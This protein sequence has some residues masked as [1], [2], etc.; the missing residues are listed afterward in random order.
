MYPC[1][2]DNNT[3]TPFDTHYLYHTA[4]AARIIKKINP[5]LHID[6]GSCL[7]FNS[8]I[9][10]F[11]PVLHCDFRPPEIRLPNLEIQHADITNLTFKNASVRSLSC[12]HVIEHIG[13]GRYG[14]LLDQ[15][16]DLK[17]VR[18]L[19]RVLAVGGHLLIC[20]PI[21]GSPR[22]EFNAHRVYS[23]RMVLDM[24]VDLKLKEYSLI[25][26][27]AY[28]KGI[29]VNASEDETNSQN[30]GC[31]CFHFIKRSIF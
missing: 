12:M 14:D 28:K 27:D 5:P 22:I 25:P 16:G 4:W 10:S 29:I 13:L 6:I 7:R 8:V 1:L 2:Q 18:E 19:I 17:G 31:G 23:Y 24:F 15:T 26:D 20:F 9:S 30:Y 21:S 11:I 3:S